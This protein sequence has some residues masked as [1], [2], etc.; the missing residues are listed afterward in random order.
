[1][2]N[3]FW[4]NTRE[5][6]VSLLKAWWGDAATAD[7]D[8]CYGYLPRLT[9]SHSTY[10]TVLAQL[11]GI[12]KGYFLFGQNPAVGSANARMQRKG[13]A[14]LDWLVVRDLVMIESA[15][16]WKT[17]RRRRPGRCAPRTSAPRSSSCPS[18]RTPRNPAASPIPS[19]CCSGTTRP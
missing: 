7:N 17:G 14:N 11:D 3:G 8:F 4:A 15:T 18:P 2:Q 12:C 1:M 9:G 5:Y 13:M 6:L 16:W 19:G 10:D